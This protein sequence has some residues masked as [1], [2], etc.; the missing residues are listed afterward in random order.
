MAAATVTQVAGAPGPN[1]SH[2]RKY[3]ATSAANQTDT[4]TTTAVAKTKLQKLCYVAVKYSA[5][6]TQAGVTVTL[7]SGEGAAFDILLYTGSA[8][9]QNNMYVPDR[10]IVLMQGDAILVS[11]TAAGGVITAT[12]TVVLEEF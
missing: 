1:G 4:A 3:S 2:Y 12:T 10:D 7:D 9:A 6:P 8:N 5:A 11:M